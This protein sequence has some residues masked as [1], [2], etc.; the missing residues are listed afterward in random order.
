MTKPETPADKNDL[1][2]YRERLDAAV[3][4]VSAMRPYAVDTLGAACGHDIL[5]VRPEESADD[6]PRILTAGGFHG[7]E[8][9][10][11]WGILEYLE[12]VDETRLNAVNHA[13]LPVVNP[14]GFVLDRRENADGDNPNRGFLE[15]PE[16]HIEYQAGENTEPSAEGKVLMRHIDRLLDLS[17]DGFITMHEDDR[18]DA[19]YLFVN[20]DTVVMPSPFAKALLAAL[21]QYFDLI[22]DGG[23][24][25]FTSARIRDG[26]WHNDYDSSFESMMFAKGVP[27]VSTTETPGSL[28]L[29]RRIDCNRALLDAFARFFADGDFRESRPES[30]AAK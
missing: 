7:N 8:V 11:P 28:D 21:T 29:R 18:M 22:P 25:A 23:K 1:N 2:A 15:L 27:F 5:L 12:T 4:R 16:T 20:E 30:A 13:F 14:A 6:L 9:A 24:G 3:T 10:G 17:R 19:G 26:V